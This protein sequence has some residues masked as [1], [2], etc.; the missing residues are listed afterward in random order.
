MFLISVCSEYS[1]DSP[2]KWMTESDKEAL[3]R[4]GVKYMDI[5]EYPELP[6]SSL[7]TAWQPCKV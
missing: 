4:A 2:A 6:V 7:N 5:T 1:E 3:L